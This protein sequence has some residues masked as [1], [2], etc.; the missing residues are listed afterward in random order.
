MDKFWKTEKYLLL[1]ENPTAAWVSE[2]AATIRQNNII[3]IKDWYANFNLETVSKSCIAYFGKPKLSEDEFLEACTRL[4]DSPETHRWWKWF[5]VK[6][7]IWFMDQAY[8][9]EMRCD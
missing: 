9:E 3:K 7:A 5:V 8:E 4:S 6:G 2:V 1:A